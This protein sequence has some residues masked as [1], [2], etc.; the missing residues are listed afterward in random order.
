[1][2]ESADFAIIILAAG[3]GTR[4]H[5]ELAK[6]LH[7]V[8]GL[9]MIVRLVREIQPMNAEKTVVVVGYQAERVRTVLSETSL[10]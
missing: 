5:S 7:P 4:M 8:G 2:E 3:K 9:P 1:M 10:S 6:V